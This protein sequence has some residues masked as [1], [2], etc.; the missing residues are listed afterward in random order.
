L[1]LRRSG[2]VAAY[3]SEQPKQQIIPLL[4]LLLLAG[5]IRTRIPFGFGATSPRLRLLTE[6]V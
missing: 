6:L 3:A 1:G 4:A 2:L 5:P